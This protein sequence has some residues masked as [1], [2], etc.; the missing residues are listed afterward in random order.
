MLPQGSVIKQSAG[1]L[2]SFANLLR[3]LPN[4]S[5]VIS[6]TMPADRLLHWCSKYPFEV[7]V[8]QDHHLSI[9]GKSC[10]WEYPGSDGLYHF[11][12]PT[13]EFLENRPITRLLWRDES[14]GASC[15][16]PLPSNQCFQ[17]LVS[18]H[19]SIN[20]KNSKE[21]YAHLKACL[22]ACKNVRHLA[23]ELRDCLWYSTL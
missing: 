20:P 19:L 13:I 2:A 4:F 23:L 10:A 17:N 14:H 8:F 11:L 1:F 15:L 7:K 16:R 3:L 9:P 22:E 6:Q 21:N 5:T 12:L 18:I